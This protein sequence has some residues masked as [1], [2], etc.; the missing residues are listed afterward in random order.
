MNFY[1]ILNLCI[2]FLSIRMVLFSLFLTFRAKKSIFICLLFEI[3]LT[4]IKTTSEITAFFKKISSFSKFLPVEELT[5]LACQDSAS[6]ESS[7]RL[8]LLKRVSLLIV[9]LSQNKMLKATQNKMFKASQN[10][11]FHQLFRCFTSSY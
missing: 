8:E 11:L 7:F 3:F 4:Q 2:R 9:Q 6:S 5:H 1:Q 10:Q